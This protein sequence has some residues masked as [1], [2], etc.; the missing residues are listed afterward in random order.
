[1]SLKDELE[2]EIKKWTAKLDS[3]L[4]GVRATDEQGEKLLANIKAYRKDS[5]HFFVKGDMVKSF[6]CL[7]W[8]WAL[9]EIGKDLGHLTK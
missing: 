2:G 3:A 4:K 5:G 9:L 1:M 8:A 6:E 7:V